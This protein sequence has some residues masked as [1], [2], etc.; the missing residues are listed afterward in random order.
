MVQM[1]GEKDIVSL[2]EPADFISH[3][4]QMKDES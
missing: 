4:V 2:K 1:K 3:M